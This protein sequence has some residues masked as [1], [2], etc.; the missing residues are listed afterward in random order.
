MRR[1]LSIN[2]LEAADPGYGIRPEALPAMLPS[3]PLIKDAGKS[4]RGELPIQEVS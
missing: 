3:L 2:S 1:K 4:H